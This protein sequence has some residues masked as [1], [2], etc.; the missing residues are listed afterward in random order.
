MLD[1]W[2]SNGSPSPTPERLL[3]AKLKT[4]ILEIPWQ[5]SSRNPSS[6]N[7]QWKLEGIQVSEHCEIV[8]VVDVVVDVDVVLLLWRLTFQSSPYEFGDH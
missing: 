3:L 1:L 6:L 5:K 2:K 4:W 8:V 7:K